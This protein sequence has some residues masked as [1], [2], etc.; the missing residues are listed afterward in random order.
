MD[1]FFLLE[2]SCL[3]KP[4]LASLAPSLV[5]VRSRALFLRFDPEMTPLLKVWFYG[6]ILSVEI[7]HI[8]YNVLH[9]VHVR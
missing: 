3:T 1:D 6:H 4:I 7:T 5:G 8:R 9:Y 2:L